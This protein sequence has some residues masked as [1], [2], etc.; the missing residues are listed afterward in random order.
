MYAVST[1]DYYAPPISYLEF[2]P[3]FRRTCIFNIVIRE[4]AIVEE[5]KTI[6]L[7][8]QTSQSD[9]IRLNPQ[10]AMIEI[11]DSTDSKRD[12]MCV[13]NIFII[14]LINTGA[15]VKFEKSL[16]EG[17]NNSVEVCAIITSPDISCPVDFNFEIILREGVGRSIM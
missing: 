4:D 16:Y 3:C 1:V 12:S 10:S 11:S 15:Y 5:T 9:L 7:G 13:Y 14:S 2:E 6:S 8:L 17:V